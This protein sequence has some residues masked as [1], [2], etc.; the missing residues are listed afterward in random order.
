ML[1][2]LGVDTCA[3]GKKILVIVENAITTNFYREAKTY[4]PRAKEGPLHL[5]QDG[6][7]SRLFV[8]FHANYSI[9]DWAYL[10]NF[11]L[12]ERLSET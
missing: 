8:N 11:D 5:R 9:L 6:G 1:P 4:Y 7:G 3:D 10:G 2:S 12:K